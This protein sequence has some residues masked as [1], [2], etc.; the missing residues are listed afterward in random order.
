MPFSI[1]GGASLCSA[2]VE[3][4]LLSES[5]NSDGTLGTA[6][7]SFF[8]SSSCAVA[9]PCTAIFEA[10]STTVPSLILSVCLLGS[11]VSC[12]FCSPAF[13][14]WFLS[15]DFGLGFSFGVMVWGAA[16]PLAGADSGAASSGFCKNFEDNKQN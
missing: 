11:K 7:L 2:S 9:L 1:T 3:L 12:D 13:S 10:A 15:R 16:S 6:V 5:A 8:A 14:S 4:I